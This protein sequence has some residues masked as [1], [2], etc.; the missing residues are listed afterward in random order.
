MPQ[1][2]IA[3]DD[4]LAQELQQEAPESEEFR[5]LLLEL[6]LRVTA[7][8]PGTPDAEL[9]RWFYAMVSD[10]ED[11]DTT[12]ER[13]RGHPRVVAAYVKPPDAMP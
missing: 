2:T 1:L 5:H 7:L 10:Q 6:G 4:A 13:L 3:V 11:L 8:H 12:L 9:A